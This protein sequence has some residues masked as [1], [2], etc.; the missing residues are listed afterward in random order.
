MYVKFIFNCIIVALLCYE[1]FGHAIIMLFYYVNLDMP[2]LIFI[3]I[4]FQSIH[5]VCQRYQKLTR[6]CT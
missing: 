3:I 6:T 1:Y 2:I 4:F 5:E